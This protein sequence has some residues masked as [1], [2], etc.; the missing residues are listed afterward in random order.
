[1]SWHIVVQVW[2]MMWPAVTFKEDQDRLSIE[3]A[4]GLL[5]ITGTDSAPVSSDRPICRHEAGEPSSQ[6][7]LPAGVSSTHKTRLMA[8]ISTF[9]DWAHKEIN[10]Q[11]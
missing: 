5:T 7:F 9:S 2:Y 4:P 1:M 10:S 8:T 3:W 6:S 11:V